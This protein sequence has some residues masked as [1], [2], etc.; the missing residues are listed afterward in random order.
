MNLSIK[1][2]FLNNESLVYHY[3]QDK[4]TQTEFHNRI[5]DLI[6]RFIKLS[7][8][9]ENLEPQQIQNGEINLRELNEIQINSELLKNLTQSNNETESKNHIPFPNNITVKNSSERRVL[10]YE[11]LFQICKK[12]FDEIK[13]IL[14]DSEDIENNDS[15]KIDEKAFGLKNKK[16]MRKYL[17]KK[18]SFQRQDS[19]L[20]PLTSN[21]FDE[22]IELIHKNTNE[23]EDSS[24]IDDSV[25]SECIHIKE[26]PQSKI[27][28]VQKHPGL[29]EKISSRSLKMANKRN[30]SKRD[31]NFNNLLEETIINLD[32]SSDK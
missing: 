18:A 15:F 12:N 14:M 24:S 3:D 22:K 29:D 31:L 20:N 27:K 13:E 19:E 2:S 21:E 23:Q 9:M 30:K 8:S 17:E 4:N 32:L 7:V 11:R 6:S 26:I 28:F 5:N 1:E 10:V 25:S 16:Y